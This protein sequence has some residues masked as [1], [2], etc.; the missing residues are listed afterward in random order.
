MTVSYDQ[1]YF[2]S[3]FLQCLEN[4]LFEPF[5]CSPKKQPPCGTLVNHS[6]CFE[7]CR[8]PDTGDHMIKCNLCCE[9][10]HYTCIGLEDEDVEGLW[11][12]KDCDSKEEL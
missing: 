7:V 8:L 9:W 2:R 10:Y 1:K 5:P 3:H 11:L 12:C 4:N 6:K